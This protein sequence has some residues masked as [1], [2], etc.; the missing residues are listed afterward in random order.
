MHLPY[1]G[2]LIN[3]PLFHETS[4]APISWMAGFRYGIRAGPGIVFAHT[5]FSMDFTSSSLDS[6]NTNDNRRYH[7]Y[8]L[9]LGA[10]FKFGYEPRTR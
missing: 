4:P 8:M 3:I 7:R 6:R 10:G 2:I 9:Y 5:R 1:A